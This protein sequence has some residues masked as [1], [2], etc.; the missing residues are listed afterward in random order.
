MVKERGG[1]VCGVSTLQY[2]VMRLDIPKGRFSRN[3]GINAPPVPVHH[4][5]GHQPSHSNDLRASMQAIR[6][7]TS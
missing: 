2:L 5:A 7:A 6:E 1:G 3:V 4:R